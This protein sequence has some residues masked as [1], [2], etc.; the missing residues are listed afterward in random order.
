M[1]KSQMSKT[2]ASRIQSSQARSGGN[3]T[4]GGFA[5]RAQSSGD[6]N[7]NAWAGQQNVGS[8]TGGQSGNNGGST[9]SGGAKN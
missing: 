3:M 2:D 5:A 9:G 7:Q 1:T 8:G 4:S 6:R